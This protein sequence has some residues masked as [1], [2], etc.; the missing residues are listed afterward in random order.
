MKDD[1]HGTY[2]RGPVTVVVTE[3]KYVAPD[4]PDWD[5]DEYERALAIGA[6]SELPV[7]HPKHPKRRRSKTPP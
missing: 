4:D 7:N 3:G 2:W 1:E 6:C 5:L